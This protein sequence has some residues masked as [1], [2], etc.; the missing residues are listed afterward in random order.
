MI[1]IL[2]NYSIQDIKASIQLQLERAAHSEEV[3]RHAIQITEGQ[4]DKIVAIY[5]WVR[6]HVR[7]VSDPV[8]IELFVSPVRLI[9]DY[10]KGD[11][12]SGDCDDHAI[13]VTALYRSIG[14]L[15]HVVLVESGENGLD[16]AF[17]TVW[18]DK[19]NCWLDI[20]TTTD[21]P[22]GWVYPNHNRIQV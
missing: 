14:I 22:L 18:S 3:R 11:F 13:L 16:H 6:E 12:I 9:K 10:F 20:D 7:Y 4:Q 21:H 8:D 15:S 19:L 5:N 17:S 2:K 1:T